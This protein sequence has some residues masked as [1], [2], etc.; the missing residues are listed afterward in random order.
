MCRCSSKVRL[1]P[2]E[3]LGL[4]V[5]LRG[6]VRG[7]ELNDTEIGQSCSDADTI[8][9]ESKYGVVKVRGSEAIDNNKGDGGR[10]KSINLLNSKSLLL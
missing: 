4:D 7:T 1:V 8:A 2:D 9:I 6:G 10:D 5:N 3:S